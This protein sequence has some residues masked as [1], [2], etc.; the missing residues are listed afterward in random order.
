MTALLDCVKCG[1]RPL[2][3]D[4]AGRGLFMSVC[5]L[6]CLLLCLYVCLYVQCS[7]VYIYIYTYIPHIR[8]YVRI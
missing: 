6:L 8:M 2:P 7:Y 1:H 5:L 3:S 4:S